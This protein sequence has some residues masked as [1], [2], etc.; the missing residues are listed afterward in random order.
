MAIN[1]FNVADFWNRKSFPK[2]EEGQYKVVLKDITLVEKVDEN[3]DDASYIKATIHFDNGRV[4]NRC[5]FREGALI[6]YS[7]LRD[8]LADETIYDTTG[9]F[10]KTVEDKELD[11]W[12]SKEAYVT[13]AGT[14]GVSERYDFTAPVV[15]TENL[16]EEIPA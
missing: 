8:Q 14:T 7:Q 11:M 13:K 12:F 16:D 1:G 15:N 5:F 2:L 6:F 4:I 10:F 3:G 9:D